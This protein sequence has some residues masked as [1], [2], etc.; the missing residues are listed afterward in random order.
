M[1]KPT[2]EHWRRAVFRSPKINDATRV[3]LLY[4]AEHM[5]ADRKV[6][7]PQAVVEEALGK[8]KRRIDA[9]RKAAIEAGLLSRVAAG[10]RGTTA[11][12]QGIFPSQERVTQSDTHSDPE[13]VSSL[14]THSVP[15]SVTLSQRERVTQS[16]T[17]LLKRT[18]PQAVTDRNVG[19]DEEHRDTPAAY[20]LTVCE[21]HGYTDCASL[22][23]SHTR[24]ESA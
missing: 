11:T 10:Y 5:R 22:S 24:R 18:T 19:N 13:R 2:V 3:Y 20:G 21:C 6:S 15:Q 8:S 4:L 17:P 7:V 9:R 14:S 12:Y 16:D 23:R 1:S